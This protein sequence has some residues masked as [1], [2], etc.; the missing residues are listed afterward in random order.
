MNILFRI[1]ADNI[2]PDCLGSLLLSDPLKYITCKKK[3][4]LKLIV[5]V[6]WAVR[7]IFMINV[8]YRRY[9]TFFPLFASWFWCLDSALC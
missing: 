1:V 6:V 2:K 3:V 8:E 7:L 9:K 5:A 4:Q